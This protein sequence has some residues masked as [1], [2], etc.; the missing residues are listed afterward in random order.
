MATYRHWSVS[1]W[2]D[3]DDVPHCQILSLDKTEWQLISNTLC[4]WRHCFVADQLWFMTR[5]WEEE[6]KVTKTIAWGVSTSQLMILV[7]SL[8]KAVQVIERRSLWV[9]SQKYIRATILFNVVNRCKYRPKLVVFCTIPVENWVVITRIWNRFRLQITRHY[10]HVPHTERQ[11]H[12][13]QFTEH[14]TYVWVSDGKHSVLHDTFTALPH[15]A[16]AS[17]AALQ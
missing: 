13:Q 9:W 14:L 4:G 17:L 11:A 12:M 7:V 5:I 1:L 8:T 6:E 16:H 10:I 3:P 15:L 2:R